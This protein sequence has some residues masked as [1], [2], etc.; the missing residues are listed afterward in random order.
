MERVW[1]RSET[2][3]AETGERLELSYYLLTEPC[4]GFDSYGVEVELLCG[5]RKEAAAVGGITPIGS[6]ILRLIDR[7][8]DGTVTP[9]GLAD[10]LQD[11][12]A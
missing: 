2:A 4:E 8:A 11:I 12:L 6:E 3:L 10:V 1:I 5:S 7:L 9:T